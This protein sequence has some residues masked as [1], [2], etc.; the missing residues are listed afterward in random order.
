MLAIFSLLFREWL[1]TFWMD[2]QDHKALKIR[3][4]ELQSEIM[5][6]NRAINNNGSAPLTN[7]QRK[8][9]IAGSES[10]FRKWFK[11]LCRWEFMI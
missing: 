2:F 8:R 10:H 3:Y 1:Y 9:G 11:L 6:E 7:S 4:R 5:E